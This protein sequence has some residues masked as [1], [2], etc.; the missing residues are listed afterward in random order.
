MFTII[1]TDI[2]TNL[3]E[4]FIKNTRRREDFKVEY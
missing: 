3:Q 4:Y 2:D 1:S